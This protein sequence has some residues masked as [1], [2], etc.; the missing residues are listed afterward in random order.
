MR[1]RIEAAVPAP[2]V[3]IDRDAGAG[4]DRPDADIAVIDVPAVGAIG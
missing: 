2:L 4:R 1:Q 3:D